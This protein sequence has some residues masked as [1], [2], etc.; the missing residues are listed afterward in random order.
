MSDE[1]HEYILVVIDCFTRF[2]E[3]YPLNKSTDAIQA[4]TA[5]LDYTGR[6]GIPDSIRLD[7]GSQF[8][9]QL[10]NAFVQLIGTSMEFT[11][12]YSKEENS[13]VER[14]NKEVNRYLRGII[15]EKNVRS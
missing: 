8:V 10:I 2:V 14:A 15:F 3:L 12:A 13:M 6:Y 1:G 9:N 4:A 7:R 5:L 11:I